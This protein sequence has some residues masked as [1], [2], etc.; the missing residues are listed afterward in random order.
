[1]FISERYFMIRGR[2]KIIFGIISS[3]AQRRENKML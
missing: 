3:R 1:M 2:M